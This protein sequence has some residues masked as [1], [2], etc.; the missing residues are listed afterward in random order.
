MSGDNAPTEKFPPQGEGTTGWVEN[1]PADRTPKRKR[2]PGWIHAI[3]SRWGEFV[4]HWLVRA[5]VVVLGLMGF[6]WLFSDDTRTN[7]ENQT[8]LTNRTFDDIATT[9]MP[10][11][12][13]QLPLIGRLFE[14]GTYSVAAPRTPVAACSFTVEFESGVPVVTVM[15][16]N[17]AEFEVHDADPT[18][19]ARANACV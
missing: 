8:T 2:E 1:P 6:F 10:Q 11:K 5:L 19:L 16:Q 17:G 14:G 18:R 4:W 3:V 13:A 15:P 9:S 12:G 7:E